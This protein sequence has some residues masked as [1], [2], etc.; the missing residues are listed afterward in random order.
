LA[1]GAKNDTGS[2]LAA[3]GAGLG[4]NVGF[5]LGAKNER[6]SFFT[7]IGAAFGAG[8]FL[9]TTGA[10][11]GAGAF[12]TVTGAGFG[13][14]AFFTTTG[15]GFDGAFFCPTLPAPFP[16]LYLLPDFVTT[17]VLSLREATLFLIGLVVILS[18]LGMVGWFLTT[19]ITAPFFPTH[20]FSRTGTAP[21]AEVD[22]NEEGLIAP[23][24]D[25]TTNADDELESV[26]S[27]KPVALKPAFMV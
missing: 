15:A 8:A 17:I 12:L 3:I 9:T 11:F 27:R 7:A 19:P 20:Q 6:G 24:D 21:N 5:G 22:A 26:K 10:G 14:G 4:A 16:S 1:L 23:F 2:F 13:A 25:G 18:P